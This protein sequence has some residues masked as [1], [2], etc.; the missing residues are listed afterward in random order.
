MVTDYDLD[1]IDCESCEL[2]FYQLIEK[3]VA[4]VQH[5]EA[6]SI[7]LRYLLSQYLP[8]HT[9]EMLRCDIF[10]DLYGSNY[11]YPAYQRYVSKW[12]G[13]RDPL[14]NWKRCKY[15][16]RVSRGEKTLGL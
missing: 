11:D 15:L 3:L 1:Y 14:D 6:K 12:C 10:H 5:L 8:K 2:E 13:G 7:Y 4:D 9:G 16:M